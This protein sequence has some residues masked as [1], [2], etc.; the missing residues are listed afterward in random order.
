MCPLDFF[1][2]LSEDTRLRSLLLIHELG[3][4]CVCELMAALDES[5]PKISRHLAQ[6]R[7]CNLLHDERRGQWVYYRISPTLPTWAT[8]ILSTTLT[9][10]YGF[11]SIN[12][13]RLAAM[14]NRPDNTSRCS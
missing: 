8:A 1:K 13:K 5:Q 9:N 11:L 7:Q 2:C 12:R 6:L 4:L 3:E 10:N 14:K